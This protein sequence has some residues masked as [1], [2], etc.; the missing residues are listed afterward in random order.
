VRRRI[1]HSTNPIEYRVH[2]VKFT[3]SGEIRISSAHRKNVSG[4]VTIVAHCSRRH[5]IGI[6]QEDSIKLFC[7][8][9]HKQAARPEIIRWHRIRLEHFQGSGRM[10]NGEIGVDSESGMGATFWF[11]IPFDAEKC[12]G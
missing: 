12:L 2:A 6:N 7:S 9:F 4:S 1:S 8:L 5:S 3:S 10:M 11:D